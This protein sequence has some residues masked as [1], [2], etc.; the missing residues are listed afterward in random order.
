MTFSP[1]R[2]TSL[3]LALAM[4]LAGSQPGLAASKKTMLRE[5]HALAAARCG[6]C[7]AVELT[8]NS[9]FRAA[10]PFRTLGQHYPIESLEEA[11]AE[12][13]FAGHPAMPSAPWTPDEIKRLI[14]YLKSINP[15]PHH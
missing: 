8:G 11:L 15:K 2:T 12:G 9:P 4:V 6:R 3:L 10:P 7:H 1:L 14:G 13:I 5:G